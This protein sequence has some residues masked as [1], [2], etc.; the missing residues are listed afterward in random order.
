MTSSEQVHAEIAMRHGARL[1]AEL[2]LDPEV[3]NQFDMEAI[4]SAMSTSALASA[5]RL[6]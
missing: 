5:R 1:A 6:K 4:K 3:A 2:G